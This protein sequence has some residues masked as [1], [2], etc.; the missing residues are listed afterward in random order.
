MNRKKKYMIV[1]GI[2]DEIE[3][4]TEEVAPDLYIFSESLAKYEYNKAV[5]VILRAIVK[6]N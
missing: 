4:I 6:I 3:N 2:K 1:I 5:K